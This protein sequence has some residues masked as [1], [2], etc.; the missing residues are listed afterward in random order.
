M[1]FRIVS[2]PLPQILFSLA[3]ISCFLSMS[4]HCRWE[5][6][7]IPLRSGLKRRGQEMLLSSSQLPRRSRQ[8]YHCSSVAKSCSTLCDP[9]DSSKPSCSVLHYVPEFAQTHV[10]WVSDAIQ[11]SHPLLPPSP[12]ALN[13][14]QHQGLFQWISSSHQVAKILELQLQ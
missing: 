4:F 9:M 5:K 7:T 8:G 6:N 2:V 3:F 10:H 12:P 13:L 1:F 11:L 14:S